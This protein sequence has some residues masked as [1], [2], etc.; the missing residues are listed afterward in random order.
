[1][2]VGG[3]IAFFVLFVGFLGVAAVLM[4]GLRAVKLI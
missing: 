4:F 1:M 2:T 3:I